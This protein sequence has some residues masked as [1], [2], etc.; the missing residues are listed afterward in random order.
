MIAT[1]LICAVLQVAPQAPP[2]A[3]PRYPVDPA[4]GRAIGATEMAPESLKL[5]VDDG[6]KLVIIDTRSAEAFEKES[7]PGAVNIPLAD[8]DARLAAYPKDTLLVFT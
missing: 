7:L 6:R 5:A 8:I 1:L 4:T 3:Q 2:P